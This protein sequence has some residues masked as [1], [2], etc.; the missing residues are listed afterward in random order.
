MQET[1]CY[2]CEGWGHNIMECP[3]KK[4]VSFAMKQHDLKGPFGYV[5]AL[6][7]YGRMS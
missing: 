1:V 7:Y 4:N 5:K 3:T 2:F 6:L